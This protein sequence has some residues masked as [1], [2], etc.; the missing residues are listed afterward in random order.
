LD[1][2]DIDSFDYLFYTN[3]YTKK[4]EYIDQKQILLLLELQNILNNKAKNPFNISHKKKPQSFF[5]KA[6]GKFISIFILSF[7]IFSIYPLY[8]FLDSPKEDLTTLKNRY[9]SYQQDEQEFKILMNSYNKNKIILKN[10][11]NSYSK[12]AFINAIFVEIN[13]KNITINSLSFHNKLLKINLISKKQGEIT[14]L[15]KELVDYGFIVKMEN[16]NFVNEKYFTLLK[17]SKK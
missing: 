17:V 5:E 16:I 15:V 12:V 8:L 6:S 9:Y 10:I 3:F 11:G 1:I 14:S 2:L 13:K 4:D 7:I